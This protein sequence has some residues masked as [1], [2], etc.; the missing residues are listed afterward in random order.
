[1]AVQISRLCPGRLRLCARRGAKG[2]LASPPRESRPWKALEGG[3]WYPGGRSLPGP[4]APTG[5]HVSRLWSEWSLVKLSWCFLLSR[6]KPP[7]PVQF[8]VWASWVRGFLQSR[9]LLPLGTVF[10]V[11]SGE[12]MQVYIESY[13]VALFH[14]TKRSRPCGVGPLVPGVPLPEN[15]AGPQSVMK[16]PVWPG[17]GRISGQRIPRNVT[18]EHRPGVC[19]SPNGA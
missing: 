17:E 11:H 9:F 5:P 16:P 2:P 7:G 12:R 10:L 8:E 14:T 3:R 6:V 4:E 15:S 19:S 13:F 1:M 18:L